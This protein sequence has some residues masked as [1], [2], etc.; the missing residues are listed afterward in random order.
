M[1][2]NR[3]PY[4]RTYFK[5]DKHLTPRAENI[6]SLILIVS[7]LGLLVYQVLSGGKL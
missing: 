7:L 4:E 1:Q 5:Q 2:E 6:L 3:I